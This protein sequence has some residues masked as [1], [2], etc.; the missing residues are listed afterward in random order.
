MNKVEP[1][2]MI[3]ASA[4]FPR[5]DAPSI[6]E[7]KDGRYK[8]YGQE[9]EIE[10]GELL[11]NGPLDNP[12]LDVRATR[13]ANDVVAGI[14]LTG[15]PSQLRSEIFSEPAMSDAEALSYLLTGR[16]LASSSAGEGDA[17]N[18]AAFALGLTGAGR[19]ASQMQSE[20]GLETLT[21]EG[22]SDSGR[23]VA[24]KRFGNR[25][26]V[27]YGYG[28]VDKLGTLLLRYQLTDRIVLESRTGTVSVFDVVY[29][30]KKQ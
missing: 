1:F 11:F 6:L 14:N 24:G 3:P 4:D 9:L 17:L 26:L 18:N 2:T 7:L 16:P 30:V 22:G 23:I 15:T 21:V 25:L 10:R 13:Q 19:I 29:S 27:E 20:L 8:A 28:I 5:H 12:Q